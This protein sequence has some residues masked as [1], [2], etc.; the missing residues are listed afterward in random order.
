[1]AGVAKD[2]SEPM[3]PGARQLLLTILRVVAALVT[4]LVAY[5]AFP[6][7]DRDSPAIG[8]VAVVGALTIF[9]FVF[10]RQLRRI[11]SSAF[12]FLR[13]AEAIVLVALVFVV[14]MASIAMAFATSDP[15]TY[16][17]PLNRM[18]ALYYTITTLATVGFGDITPTA[19]ATRAF[20]TVQIVLGV[21]L[22]GVGLRALVVV[23]QKVKDERT[24]GAAAETADTDG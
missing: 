5:F 3:S 17:E 6:L 14:L 23:A 24:G 1:M 21:V 18:D 8:L 4:L 9:G 2:G 22:L 20:T 16:S 13:A 11:R 19:T 7:S 15:S 12:P 10:Y